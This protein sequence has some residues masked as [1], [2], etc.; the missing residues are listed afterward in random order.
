[1]AA[2]AGRLLADVSCEG[3]VGIEF[4]CPFQPAESTL[5]ACEYTVTRREEA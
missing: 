1:M 4:N 5:S 2:V 3:V